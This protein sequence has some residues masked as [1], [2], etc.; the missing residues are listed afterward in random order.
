M[1]VSAIVINA[2]GTMSKGLVKG[3][4]DLE[5]REQEETVQNTASLSRT[6]R[7]QVK[8]CCHS[9]SSERPSANAGVK[10]SSET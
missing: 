6:L 3:L 8:T 1:T 2:L 7:R 10:N 5:I 4:E 9:D